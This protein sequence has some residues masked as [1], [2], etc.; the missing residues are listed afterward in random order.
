M[1]ILTILLITSLFLI[2]SC[3]RGNVPGGEKP[4]DTAAALKAVQTGT[5]G[6]RAEFITNYP[7]SILYDQNELIA[8]VDLKNR[9]NYDL[10]PY[11]CFVQVT[12]FDP[13]IITGGFNIPRSCA[14]NLE[15]LEGK[16]IYNIEGDFNQIEFRSPRVT[17]PP[18]VFEYSPNLNLVTCYHYHTLANPLV[19]VD[20]LFYQ[21]TSEQKSCLPQNV[22]MGGG[23]GAPVGISYVGVDMVGGGSSGASKAVFEINVVNQGGGRVLSPYSDLRNCGG[24]SLDYTD[25][26]KV[27]YSVQ[28]SGGSLIDCKPRDGFVR[29][30]NNNGKIV[31]SF[32]IHGTSSFETPLMIDLDYNYIY[33]LQKKIRIVKT[34]E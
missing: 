7:P 33:N 11:D 14:E 23:Q 6:V 24:A 31:C 30:N 22:G 3:K 2:S 8:I 26:D 32:N 16:N 1:V 4:L 29:L 18:G 12:G 21:I 10:E 15:V 25:L 17:L 28:L 13:N 19:C 27:A 5:E 20:P 34:P 9:G